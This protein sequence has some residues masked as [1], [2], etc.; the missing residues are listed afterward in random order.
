MERD[1]LSHRG[2]LKL[3]LRGTLPLAEAVRRLALALAHD[4]AEAGTLARIAAL[5]AQNRL[6]A[7]DADHLRAAFAFLT[8]LLLRQQLSDY[9]EGIPASDFVDPAALTEREVDLLRDSLRAI[10]DFRARVRADLSRARCSDVAGWGH[11]AHPRHG[12]HVGSATP[13]RGWRRPR[14]AP[15][16]LL[17]PKRNRPP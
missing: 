6:G 17:G 7:D 3:K 2:G 16:R 10:N 15:P 5:Q 11:T 12:R 13:D 1:G 9:R 14:R 8:G 4:V